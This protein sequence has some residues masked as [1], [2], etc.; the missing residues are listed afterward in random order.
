MARSQGLSAES[1][2]TMTF[3]AWARDGTRQCS[4]KTIPAC[5]G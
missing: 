4:R 3:A 2:L 5:C 1:W